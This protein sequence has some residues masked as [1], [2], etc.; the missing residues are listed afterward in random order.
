MST[1]RDFVI[2]EVRD[3]DA[4]WPELVLMLQALNKYHEPLLGLALRSDWTARARL[5]FERSLFAPELEA[6]LLIAHSAGSAVGFMSA[7]VSR[8]EDVFE[9]TF[10]VVDDAYV[11]ES[12]RS[13]GVGRALLARVEIWAKQ[14]GIFELGLSVVL[15]NESGVAAWSALGFHPTMQSM[16]KQLTEA[17]S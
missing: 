6:L 15:A 17:S 13:R 3:L 1:E 7:Y 9:E 4:A 11:S 2:E 12:E 14:L 10:V 16:R 8:S 5:Y